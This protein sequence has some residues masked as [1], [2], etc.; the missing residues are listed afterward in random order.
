MK[1]AILTGLDFIDKH[2]ESLESNGLY[3]IQSNNARIM[4]LFCL[5]FISEGLKNK[6]SCLIVTNDNPELLLKE[7]RFL[8]LDFDFYI[9][10]NQLII[11]STPPELPSIFANPNSVNLVINDFNVYY[12]HFKPKRVLIYPIKSIISID[13]LEE[14]ITV[15]NRF[16]SFIQSFHATTYVVTEANPPF[17]IEYLEKITTGLFSI[18]YD[19]NNEYNSIIY[20]SIR[21]NLG[22]HSFVFKLISMKYF[23]TKEEI[24]DVQIEWDQIN[25][26]FFPDSIPEIAEH[27][28]C[29]INEPTT[30][31]AYHNEEQLYDLIREPKC[32][33]VCLPP[34]LP[35]ISG[36]E[37]CYRLRTKYN[38]IVLFQFD[39]IN[40]SLSQKNRAKRIGANRFL[41][42]PLQ[43]ESLINSIVDVFPFIKPKI[44]R[45]ENLL[46]LEYQKVETI[47]NRTGQYISLHNARRYLHLYA[48]ETIS[49]PILL[50][51]V[52][53]SSDEPILEKL[54][55]H[56]PR[57]YKHLAF[58]FSRKDIKKQTIYC[59]FASTD[60]MFLEHFKE[61]IQALYSNIINNDFRYI[62][63]YQNLLRKAP[64]FLPSAEYVKTNSTNITFHPEITT[65]TYP[66]DEIDI[67]RVLDLFFGVFYV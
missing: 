33:I 41:D 53:L 60:E 44:N 18:Q 9:E 59:V 22:Y 5:Y 4:R 35:H 42:L 20:K 25:T 16:E 37:L 50:H 10:N 63:N 43:M 6:E 2:I 52:S 8:N 3:L 15:L 66:V 38:D 27:I 31:V 48:Q 12:Q 29:I 45:I 1:P 23:K 32:T 39:S 47:A 24:A 56:M 13:D 21:N 51:F 19:V 61:D 65:Y 28:S 54:S 7:A 36:Y 46:K 58:L 17:L 62:H 30:I 34:V 11:L 26:I 49:Q 14:H 67:D 57:N 55:Y 64:E 40:T